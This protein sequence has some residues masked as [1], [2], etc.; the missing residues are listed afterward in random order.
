MENP[1]NKDKNEHKNS[2]KSQDFNRTSNLSNFDS[3]FLSRLKIKTSTIETTSN[4]A[5]PPNQKSNF[6]FKSFL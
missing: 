5:S 4:G 2:N 6:T 1:I 3:N